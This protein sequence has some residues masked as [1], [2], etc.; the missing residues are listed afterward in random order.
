MLSGAAARR[1]LTG[2]GRCAPTIA[3][4]LKAAAAL[5][6]PLQPC[7]R[8][9]W[10]D[11][12]LFDGDAV[13]GI[14]DPSAARTDSVAADIARLVGSLVGDDRDAWDFALAAYE[15]VRPLSAE[16]QMLVTVLD[17]SGTLLS[18][19]TWLWRIYLAE[20]VIPQPERVATRLAQIAARLDLLVT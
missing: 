15:G 18:G 5:Y 9:V 2:F 7:L 12:L 13:S 8:D 3:H 14:I 16:E 6:V 19:M 20:A 11:H 10:H 1:I 17:R 4:E